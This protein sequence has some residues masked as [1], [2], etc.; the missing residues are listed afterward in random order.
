MSK[1]P[2]SRDYMNSRVHVNKRLSM[3]VHWPY[4]FIF[5]LRIHVWFIFIGKSEEFSTNTTLSCSI[6]INVQS[7]FSR[8]T[9]GHRTVT[10]Y[11]YGR[12]LTRSTKTKT[13]EKQLTCINTTDVRPTI[14]TT[15]SMVT[16]LRAW[17]H[18]QSNVAKTDT[19]RWARCT[20]ASFSRCAIAIRLTLQP[21]DRYTL[22]SITTCYRASSYEPKTIP[23]TQ[24]G[25]TVNSCSI[26]SA[27]GTAPQ[28]DARV[29]RA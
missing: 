1:F 7:T 17:R 22:V 24:R 4:E 19:R 8:S 12:R 26:R 23:A 27:R 6:R 10:E 28:N 14:P 21:C 18:S 15:V 13:T 11:H 25:K 3:N 5:C 2:Y 9:S 29:Y 16:T 20:R